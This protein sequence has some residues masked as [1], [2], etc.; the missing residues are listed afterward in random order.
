[1]NN[2]F[3]R[4]TFRIPFFLVL[5]LLQQHLGGIYL[6]PQHAYVSVR[7]SLNLGKEKTTVHLLSLLKKEA[8]RELFLFA[9]ANG[10]TSPNSPFVLSRFEA[11]SCLLLGLVTDNKGSDY[12]YVSGCSVQRLCRSAITK[13]YS[14]FIHVCK[15]H[16]LKS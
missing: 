5:I 6:N 2:S 7:H 11:A 12:F 10:D 4:L 14:I 1:M 8:K 9:Q 16:W 15:F 3:A 13:Q